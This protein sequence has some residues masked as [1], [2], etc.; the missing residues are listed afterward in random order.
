MLQSYTERC[1]I[2]AH[3]RHLFE[4]NLIDR[5]RNELPDEPVLEAEVGEHG[6]LVAAG[7]VAAFAAEDVAE[8]RHRKLQPVAEVSHQVGLEDVAL[9]ISVAT[10]IAGKE[11]SSISPKYDS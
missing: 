6:V 1:A 2:K 10:E 7:E 8:L 4:E 5:L 9:R 11:Q 3:L